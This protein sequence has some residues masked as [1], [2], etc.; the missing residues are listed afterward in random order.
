MTRRK[1]IGWT[2]VLAAVLLAGTAAADVPY[3]P[4]P[5]SAEELY[6]SA[7]LKKE[8][9]GDLDGAI[10]LFQG[11]IATFPGN[12]DVA[13]KAQLQIGLWYEKLGKTEAIKAYELVVEKYAGQKE[14][15]AAARARLAELKREAPKGLSVVKLKGE[16][17][18]P[19]VYIQP[20]EI[21]PDGGSVVGVEFVKG[22]NIVVY[23]LETGRLTYIT[24]HAWS[25]KGY[26]YTYNPVMSPDGKEI[27]YYSC[28]TG[29]GSPGSDEHDLIVADLGGG[30]RVLAKDKEEWQIPN[31]WLPDG[32]AIL[33]IKGGPGHAPQLGLAPRA[34]GD[35]KALATYQNRKI[36]AGREQR[37]AS[38]SPDGRYIVFTDAAPGEKSDIYIVG[39]GGGTPKPLVKHPAEEKSP[40]WSPDGKHVVFQSLRHGSWALW[41]VAVEGGAT[42]GEPFL[43]RDGM[44]DSIIMN[45]TAR[46]LGVWDSFM[47][48]DIYLV[49]TDP[50]T[51]EPAGD[52]RQLEYA[53]TGGNGTPVWSPDGKAFAFL[54]AGTGTGV[55]S[56]V[57]F[58]TGA[59]EFSVPAAHGMGFLR[60]TPDGSALGMIL[61]DESN[62]WHLFRLNPASG[63]WTKIPVPVAMNTPFDW[64]AKGN[65]I[66]FGKPGQ[67]EMK[68]GIVEFDL[69]MA[70][71]RYVYRPEKGFVSVVRW[72]DSSP[73][74]KRL[75]FLQINASASA[76]ELIVLNLET[77]EV[78]T[79]AADFGYSSWSPDGRMLIGDRALCAKGSKQSL[80]LVPEAGGEVKEIDLSKRLPPRSEIRM[81]DWS[82]DGKKIIFTLR[83]SSSEVSLLQ[84][85]IPPEK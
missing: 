19:G 60:W 24:D 3:R 58:G 41:G 56:V 30:S 11:I 49:D 2:A 17:D 28:W 82:P 57:V 6:Q 32:S 45:W 47:M 48:N 25:I 44:K 75:A 13:A 10:K 65:I 79:A 39:S 70:A 64:G 23:D 1:T 55:P 36:E 71:E 54:R 69:E 59:R 27:A 34:G 81:P 29:D 9:E 35:F 83:S 12:K 7:L 61:A 20:V 22:Q 21:S 43:I 4:A 33:T 38:V 8:A 78:H 5:Q 62:K 63:T 37:S 68:G 51:G 80:C 16:W 15:V 26:Y 76:V 14:Q 84:N 50:A 74:R 46:G 73:D 42:A 67:A 77:G 66:Y 53:P 18:K 40:R 85:L 52:P 72:I 31:A